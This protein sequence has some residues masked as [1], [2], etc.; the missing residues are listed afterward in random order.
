MH[1][2]A[3]TAAAGNECV[4][5]SCDW[6]EISSMHIVIVLM[7]ST[8]FGQINSNRGRTNLHVLTWNAL[9]VE[10]VLRKHLRISL[11]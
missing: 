11:R 9:V 1:M 6:R 3:R 2:A 7:V 4:G 5:M 10:V 8:G